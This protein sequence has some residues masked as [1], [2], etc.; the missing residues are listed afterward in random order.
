MAAQLWA[1]S[2]NGDERFLA[3]AVGAVASISVAARV[4]RAGA[5]AAGVVWVLGTVC[6][7]LFIWDQS[8]RLSFSSGVAGAGS[9]DHVWERLGN[10]ISTTMS[11]TWGYAIVAILALCGWLYAESR[12][13]AVFLDA[14]DEI[15]E[16]RVRDL[17]TS[18]P[19]DEET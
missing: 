3:D 16:M 11:A 14:I 4:L 8:E 2:D 7:A 5:I 10:T 17:P 13:A 12:R 15:D 18:S 1:T 6:T 19:G 9:G